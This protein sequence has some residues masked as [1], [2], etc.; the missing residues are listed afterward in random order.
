MGFRT[1]TDGHTDR[2]TYWI[3]ILL[4]V[5]MT[6]GH[7]WLRHSN[8]PKRFV[9]SPKQRGSQN[10][11]RGSKHPENTLLYITTGFFGSGGGGEGFYICLWCGGRG[12][13]S[14]RHSFPSDDCD[15][16]WRSGPGLYTWPVRKPWWS[17]PV[18]D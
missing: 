7:P 11:T 4:V 15:A 5:P 1:L 17:N 9:W 16:L 6:F 3:N 2:H 18:T 12:M 8:H 10:N 14:D 13:R